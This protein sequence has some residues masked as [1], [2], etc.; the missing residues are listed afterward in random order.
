MESELALG[1][2]A[3]Q[4]VNSESRSTVMTSVQIRYT[5]LVLRRTAETLF[6]SGP[7][8]I[9]ILVVME[10]HGA[11]RIHL[12]RHHSDNPERITSPAH[13]GTVNRHLF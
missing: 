8:W 2:N 5:F 11:R 12:H 13:V 4:P 6:S 9:R 7:A 1:D 10:R 3:N